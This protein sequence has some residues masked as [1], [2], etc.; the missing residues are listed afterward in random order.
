MIRLRPHHLLCMLT[1]AG[2]GYTPRFTSGMDDLIARLGGGEEILLIDGPDDICAPWLE[3]AR[4]DGAAGSI[5]AEKAAAGQAGT[6]IRPPH[7][8]ES[9]IT[10]RDQKAAADIAALLQQEIK[11]GGRLRLDAALI[12]RLRHAF[13]DNVIRSGCA[14]CEWKDFCDSLGA[15]DFLG[16]RLQ[17]R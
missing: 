4:L 10:Q 13:R 12:A 2:R 9:R 7:C 1:Y 11:A 3:E 16:C 14:A 17:A 8:H 6:E 15:T 5:A